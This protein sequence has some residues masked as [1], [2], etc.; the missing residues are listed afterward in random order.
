MGAFYVYGSNIISP[1]GDDLVP[2][3]TYKDAKEFSQ[4]NRGMRILNFK[5]IHQSLINLLNGR[6]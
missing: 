5:D 2:F 1:A 3:A 4:K 6:I